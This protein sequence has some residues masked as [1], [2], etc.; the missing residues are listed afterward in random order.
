MLLDDDGRIVAVGPARQ[1]PAPAGAHGLDFPKAVLLPGFI[2]TH[3]HLELHGLRHAVQEADFYRWLQRVR[4]F[5]ETSTAESYVTAARAG[6]HEAWRFGTTT[7]ADTGTS[8]ATVCALSELGGRGVYYQEV[9]APEPAERES[10]LARARAT[11]ERLAAQA[12]S[13]VRLG[14]SPHAPYT[15]SPEL[16]H[17]VARF[18]RAAGLP[19]AAHLAE[20]RAETRFLA[21][22]DGPFADLWRE[23]RL[24]L[25]G[26]VRSPVAYAHQLG[27]LGS[28]LLAIHLVQVDDE[29]LALLARHDVAVAVCPRSNRRH[30]HGVPPLA[31]LLERGVRIGLGTD[32]VASVASLDLLAEAR[33][34]QQLAGCSAERVLRL[35][36]VEAAGAIGMDAAVGTLEPGKWADVCVLRVPRAA[37][38]AEGLARGVLA[39]DRDAVVATLLAGRL[40]Y[41]EGGGAASAPDQEF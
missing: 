1:V 22:H 24:P 35:L 21:Q 31:A 28:D 37:D 27:L 2:N 40:V 39:C 32:S 7:V 41:G 30:G 17:D 23:R 6:V 34:A 14:V 3:T 38:D 16:L 18:A 20:S 4:R 9:I 26:P 13:A 12:S 5:K 33:L 8:G 25:P 19:L 29:D 15:V 11:L 36:T 10:A